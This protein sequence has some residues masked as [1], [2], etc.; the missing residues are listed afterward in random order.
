MGANFSGKSTLLRVLRKR[1]LARIMKGDIPAKPASSSSS[2]SLWIR[3]VGRGASAVPSSGVATTPPSS[4]IFS[5]KFGCRDA[6]RIQV[7]NDCR[8]MM[9]F[10]LLELENRSSELSV[11]LKLSEYLEV[12]NNAPEAVEIILNST[13]IQ[14]LTGAHDIINAIEELW[15]IPIVKTVYW[16]LVDADNF[17]PSSIYFGNLDRVYGENIHDLMDNLDLILPPKSYENCAGN[18]K[19][20]ELILKVYLS[21]TFFNNSQSID[22]QSSVCIPED[23]QSIVQFEKRKWCVK[24]QKPASYATFEFNERPSLAPI[25]IY[26]ISLDDIDRCGA[27]NKP[28][29]D[30]SLKH[31]TQL[32]STPGTHKV[33]VF[34]KADLFSKKVI[35]G[36]FKTSKV[37][38]D[39]VGNDRDP[40]RI[41]EH[42][43]NKLW[44]LCR[45]FHE[46][47]P[48]YVVNLTNMEEMSHF[49]S[50]LMPSNGSPYSGKS[51][52]SRHL[53]KMMESYMKNNLNNA[54]SNPRQSSHYDFSDITIRF[55]HY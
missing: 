36:K 32:L 51:F 38:P 49:C 48:Y 21:N 35:S 41:F 20:M 55:R 23:S 13:M 25:L 26:L 6:F 33:L 42:L 34:T 30:S 12:K 54:W 16:Q 50:L 8:K 19:I 40:L 37:F 10:I 4:S 15:S 9:R 44:M 24:M 14:D 45:K 43:F 29:F 2:P 27:R 17:V 11:L 28:S 5:N 18:G 7:I 52:I 31:F 22:T 1:D 47:V 46:I 39:F 53:L 3:H